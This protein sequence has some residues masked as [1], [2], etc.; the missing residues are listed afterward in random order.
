MSK[1]PGV[2]ESSKPK[3]PNIFPLSLLY[4]TVLV[5]FA[6]TQLFTF[7]DF[8]RLIDSFWLPGG[9]PVAY[10]LSGFI[11]VAEVFALPFLLRMK[12][13]T[14]MRY[15]SMGLGWIVPAFW[16][17]VSLWLMLTTNAIN[18]V[19]LLGTVAKLTPGWWAV[20][21]SLALAILA[22]WISWG[23]WPRA[24]HSQK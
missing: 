22:I 14:L 23:M 5:V 12:I 4:A 15:V 17:F 9:S 19:G 6:V 20:F 11:V 18:N 13:S 16:L 21:V 2:T 7:N 1:F 24:R 3:T 8:Q 10:F